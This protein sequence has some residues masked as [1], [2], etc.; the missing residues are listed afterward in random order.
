LNTLLDG[1]KKLFIT[2]IS[3]LAAGCIYFFS[4][5]AASWI[6]QILNQVILPLGI[7]ICGML[8]NG[9]V[10]GF[11]KEKIMSMPLHVRSLVDKTPLTGLE[12]VITAGGALLLAL[13]TYFIPNANQANVASQLVS[14]VL[15]PLG[16]LIIGV[17]ATSLH[18]GI[19]KLKLAP[20]NA[21]SVTGGVAPNAQN[22]QPA[23]PKP[24]APPAPP[25]ADVIAPDP[26]DYVPVNLD[27]LQAQA[28]AD[29][30]SAQ[31]P[32]TPW[33]LASYFKTVLANFDGRTIPACFRVAEFTRMVEQCLNLY[34]AG[35]TWY[36]KITTPPTAEQVANPNTYYTQ[37]K[38]AYMAANNIP[39]GTRTFAELKL[40]IEDFNELYQTLYGL[41]QM[42]G[43]CDWSIYGP[44]TPYSPLEAG[45]DWVELT[46]M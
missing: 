19:N 42:T 1:Y 20:V 41:S 12:P 26:A 7:I 35:F 10:A 24:A 32:Q 30:A 5:A 18:I 34:D 31:V 29:M 45:Q 38:E 37:L 14:Q 40:A 9:A 2:F 33:A 21:A 16:M 39:C 27:N 8:A 44:N 15:V 23:S 4:P 46:T 36:T 28:V 6:Q 25:R 13:I 17:Q 3:I 22:A 43:V 11:D